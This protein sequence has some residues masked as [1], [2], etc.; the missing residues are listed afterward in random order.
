MPDSGGEARTRGGMEASR[1][2]AIW[3]AGV[4]AVRRGEEF[5]AL[6]A[7]RYWEKMAPSVDRSSLATATATLLTGLRRPE[8]KIES[9]SS[10]ALRRLASQERLADDL[11]SLIEPFAR[12]Q[13]NKPTGNV[14]DAASRGRAVAVALSALALGATSDACLE[15]LVG[16]FLPVRRRVAQG[17]FAVTEGRSHNES[18]GSLREPSDDRPSRDSRDGRETS[19]RR[20]ALK[21]PCLEMTRVHHLRVS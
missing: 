8:P 7:V 9:A 12:A 21:G 17:C 11:S 3:R 4:E 15:P 18:L 20:D 6:S 2:Q 10:R 19:E 5:A 1:T 13:C 14:A 16:T